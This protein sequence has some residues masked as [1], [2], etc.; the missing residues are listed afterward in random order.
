LAAYRERRFTA[1]D[2]LGLHFCDYGDPAAAALPLLCLAGLTRNA[3][4]F[5]PLASRLAGDRRVLCLDLRGRGRSD[6]DPQWRNYE[7]RAYLDDIAQMLALANAHRF[8]AVGTSFGG[9]LAMALGAL[10]PSA[11][12]GAV[13][14]DVGPEI[15]Q[16]FV[17]DLLAYIRTDRPQPD[18]ASAAEAIRTHMP[19]AVFQ[20]EAMFQAMVRNTYREGEDGLLHFD[21][22]VNIVR[23]LLEDRRPPPDLWPFFRGLRAI[24]MLAFRGETSDVLSPDCFARMGREHPDIRRVT[25]PGTGH[26]PTLTEPEC[27]AALDEFL[28]VF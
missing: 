13:L 15:G 11:L 3:S 9:V 1:R 20:T 16:G 27:I 5:H 17:D 4:D 26:A 22:D 10:M 12:A 7:P 6:R 28:R 14:N 21:W 23:P 24:P 18:W 2:G 19:S 8:I 25:V